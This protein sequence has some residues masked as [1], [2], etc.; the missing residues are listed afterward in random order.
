MRSYSLPALASFLMVFNRDFAAGH[1]GDASALPP[2]VFPRL[3]LAFSG[4]VDVAGAYPPVRIPGGVRISM[5]FHSLHR[6]SSP[7]SSLQIAV[8]PITGG[9]FSGPVL[10]ATIDGGL[11]FPTILA[12]G[13][14]QDAFI[15]IY[16]TTSHNSSLLVQVTGTGNSSSQFADA[17]CSFVIPAR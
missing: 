1:N 14:R 13:T 4:S 5:A 2:L 12:N 8:E 17:V 7:C 9:N 3:S 6:T 16:G 11:A 15:T 10:N